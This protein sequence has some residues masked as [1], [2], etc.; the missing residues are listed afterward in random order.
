MNLSFHLTQDK[1]R[2]IIDQHKAGF[3]WHNVK[4][5]AVSRH[6]FTR[7]GNAPVNVCFNVEMGRGGR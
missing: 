7:T 6:T 5:K 3:T 4:M 1:S 2:W